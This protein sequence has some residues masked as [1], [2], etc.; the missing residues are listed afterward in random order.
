MKQCRLAYLCIY[1]CIYGRPSRNTPEPRS[2]LNLDAPILANL[3][4]DQLSY[5]FSSK[6]STFLTFIFKVKDSNRVHS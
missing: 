4:V 3:C 2:W 5:P 6:S 1:V